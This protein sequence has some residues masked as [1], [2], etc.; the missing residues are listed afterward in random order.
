MP[1]AKL[2]AHRA[3]QE[4]AGTR[5]P[6]GHLLRIMAAGK[7]H[8]EDPRRRQVLRDLDRGDG[9]VADARILDLTADEV[10]EHPLHLRFDAAVAAPGGLVLAGHLV[11]GSGAYCTVRATSVRVKHSIWSPTRTSW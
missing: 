3:A 1:Q 9:D 5:Q 8:E 7:G 6:L 4:A 10:G 2:P 11:S